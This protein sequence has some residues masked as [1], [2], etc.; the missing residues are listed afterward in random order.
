MRV[1]RRMYLRWVEAR[2]LFRSG[3]ARMPAA[4]DEDYDGVT[5]GGPKTTKK[6]RWNRFKWTL[7]CANSVVGLLS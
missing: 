2:R 6:M 1:V 5:P 7:L 3:E 4:G